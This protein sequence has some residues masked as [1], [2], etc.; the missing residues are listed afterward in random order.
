METLHIRDVHEDPRIERSLENF[1]AAP[2]LVELS[3]W[4]HQGGARIWSDYLN[5]GKLPS[6]RRLG[7]HEVSL[8]RTERRESETADD[9]ERRHVSEVE[10]QPCR[11]IPYS[12]LEVLVA[13]CPEN[14]ETIPDFPVDGF[15]S[16]SR[17][18]VSLQEQV[19]NS[20]RN[21]RPFYSRTEI[22]HFIDDW[23]EDIQKLSIPST[24]N[25][26]KIRFFFCGCPYR[27]SPSIYRYELHGIEAK[28]LLVIDEIDAVEEA[29]SVEEEGENF[30]RTEM[31][32]LTSLL[33]PSFVDSLRRAGRLRD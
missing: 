30:E 5:K 24:S 20:S 8:Y 9:S 1:R 22:Y 6:L 19:N 15:L 33:F 26:S 25:S 17:Y 32:D 18:P 27:F 14:F 31:D 21:F 7:F 29:R 2:N 4:N 11:N 3:I 28:G 13:A 23:F 12:Q 16:L 10:I